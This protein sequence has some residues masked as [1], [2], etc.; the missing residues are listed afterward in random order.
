MKIFIVNGYPGSGKTLFQEYC[1]S[2]LH[3]KFAHCVILRTSVIDPV[4]VIARRIGWDGNKDERG[5]KFLSDLKDALD[6]YSN[7]TFNSI[8]SFAKSD[9]DFIF[10][11]ARSDYDIDYAVKT[12]GAISIFI[13]KDNN[14]VGHLNHADANVRDYNYQYYINNNGT[15]EDFYNATNLFLYKIMN[16]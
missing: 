13:D 10:M 11:D 8:D 6:A 7:F 16:K 9:V 2:I 3:E 15:K 1:Y 14:E 5:R 4:K 12:Y